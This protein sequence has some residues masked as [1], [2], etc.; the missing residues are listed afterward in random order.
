MAILNCSGSNPWPKC[1]LSALF[2]LVRCLGKPKHAFAFPL[3]L[4]RCHFGESNL[5]PFGW[6]STTSLSRQV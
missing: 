6:Q 4:N 2:R 3:V 5:G 1:S